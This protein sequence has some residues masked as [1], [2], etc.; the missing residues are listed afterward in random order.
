MNLAIRSSIFQ[1]MLQFKGSSPIAVAL[2]LLVVAIGLAAP[3]RAAA[4]F[5]LNDDG[6]ALV[7]DSGAGLVFKVST[8][9]G[10]IVSLRYKGGPELQEPKR[11]SQIDSGLGTAKVTG[12]LV[13]AN[14]VKITLATDENNGVAKS[15]THYILVRRDLNDIFMATYATAEPS[16]GELRWITR[17]E[18]SQFLKSPAPSNTR[19]ASGAIESK[20]VFGCFDGTTRSKYYGDSQTHG[21]DR[22][23]D[24]TF[25]GASGQGVGVWMIYGS[26]ESS[27]GG[28]FHRDIQSQSAEV[29]NYMNSGHNMTEPPRLKVLHGPYALVFTD[30]LP[31][32]LPIDFSWIDTAGLDLIG[33]VPAS[34]RGSVTGR[35]TGVPSQLRGVVGFANSE[36][37]YWA[38]IDA[39]S[40]YSSPL[41]KP[42]SYEAKLYQGEL[43]VAFGK[44]SVRGGAQARLDLAAA[45]SPTALFRI[46]EWDGTPLEFL[47]GPKIVT[48]HP[49][50]ARM[51]AWGPVTFTVGVDS[52]TKF[53]A[54][55]LRKVN[56]PTTIKFKLTKAQITDCQLRIGIICSYDGARPDIQIN[57]WKP[58]NLPESQPQP[59][60]RSFTIGTYR[61]NN[62]LI[63]YKIP[64]GAFVDGENTL[65]INP[66]SGSSDLSPWLSA[67]WAYDAI[68]LDA[69]AAN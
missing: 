5:G 55:Q 10:D 14:I 44:V 16:V 49:S 2:S 15:L 65:A 35:V 33:Y 60:S 37:Q 41:M 34:R 9:N 25:C 23:M 45:P 54:L 40:S 36:A 57:A 61:G 31:P 6:K 67:G 47:N 29:Y 17:L 24:M 38:P 27:S 68:E 7:V 8:S 13:G 32:P 48:M 43:A 28:P 11:H 26:R 56:S 18:P 69:E 64:A 58:R 51:S 59:R 1:S 63:T 46:G 52:P 4:A 3:P 21:K 12:A 53:P 62:S 22:A 42:G 20:D 19:E 50:D 30:G 39:A 66:V